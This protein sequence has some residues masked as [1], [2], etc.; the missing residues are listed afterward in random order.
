MTHRNDADLLVQAPGHAPVERT[1]VVEGASVHYI[2]WGPADAPAV[3]LVHGGLAHARW[4]D[5]IAPHLVG[6][7]VVALDLTG[8]GDSGTRDGYDMRQWGREIVGVVRAAG[9]QRPV[10]VGH[11]MG[12]YPSVSAAIDAPEEI[13]GVITL[14]SRFN[15]GEYI[16]GYKKSREFTSIDEALCNFDPVHSNSAIAVPTAVLRHIGETSLRRE[17]ENWRW[18]RDDNYRITQAPLRKL[19]PELRRP[20][21]IVQT[22]HGLV[23]DDL[24][25][26]MRALTPATSITVKIPTA[27]HNPMLEQPV[28]LI[29]V[30]RTLLTTEWK[31]SP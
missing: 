9:L 3:V 17:G 16:R 19:L 15:D 11:S 25:A 22:E 7:R 21:A 20:L 27:G 28:A 30:L 12:G 24:A 14:D 31:D 6:H 4:W 29:S 2:D 5:H 8:H 10:V 18:K 13:R 26:E 23:T 1:I